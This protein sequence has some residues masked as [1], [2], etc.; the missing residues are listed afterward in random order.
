MSTDEII[1][2]RLY[3]VAG[4]CYF[5]DESISQQDFDELSEHYYS[6]V[7]ALAK[8]W[9]ERDAEYDSQGRYNTGGM[10]EYKERL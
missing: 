9:R 2:S 7:E 5:D 1:H 10:S 6:L 3:K 8:P 4:V